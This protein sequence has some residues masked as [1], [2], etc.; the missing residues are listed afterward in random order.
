LIL[1]KLPVFTETIIFRTREKDVNRLVGW[2]EGIQK[3]REIL[4]VH[5]CAPC[6]GGIRSPSEMK[7]NGAATARL[8]IRRGIVAYEKLECMGRIFLPHLVKEI[9]RGKSFLGR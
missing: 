1:R 2:G 6:G 8:G 3:G 7:K 4:L 5:G 9:I